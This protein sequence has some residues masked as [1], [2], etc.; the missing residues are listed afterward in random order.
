[1][2]ILGG[3]L[4]AGKTTVLNHLLR[5]ADGRRLGVCVN[6]FGAVNVDALMVASQVDGVVG[7]GNGCLCCAT[8][9]DGFDDAL[10]RLVRTDVDAVVVETSGIADP[11]SMI[12]RVVGMADPQVAYGGMVYVVDAAAAA[13]GDLPA[14]A[15][16]H[17]RVAD[18]VVVNKA[19]LVDG[20]T[21]ASVG[22]ELDTVNPTAARVV[23][24]EG[25]VD[26]A[27]LVDAGP[28]PER[29]GAEQLTLDD[30]L[31]AQDG[32]DDGAHAG[33]HHLH[34]DYQQFTWEGDGPVNPRAVARL[35][36]RPPAGCYRIKGWVE[37]ESEFFRGTLEL[38]AVGGRVRAARAARRGEGASRNTIVLIGAGLDVA[39]A[40]VACA[41]LTA[42]D[43][44]D[45]FGPLSLLRYDPDTAQGAG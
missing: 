10:A 20:A 24:A 5:H 13:A 7:F 21:L 26:P 41:D 40:R 16:R 4:G 31:R 3:F 36:E 8:D 32:P 39:S 28:R 1:V 11:V 19:D 15:L 25:A 9:S 2:I 18:L 14:E 35:V 22:A 6:D 33:H 45:E 42:V 38:S 23:T 44:D 27:I 43:A 12:R 17:T 37:V 34:E 29:V 30:L